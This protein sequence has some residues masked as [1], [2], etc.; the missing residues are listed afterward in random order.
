MLQKKN[1][2]KNK[3]S[4]ECYSESNLHETDLNIYKYKY[5]VKDNQSYNILS[6]NIN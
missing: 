5:F 3:P 4:R 2:N 6:N 1:Q